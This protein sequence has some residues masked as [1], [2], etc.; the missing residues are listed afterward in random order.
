MVL[1]ASVVICTRN[2]PVLLSQ[3]V[4]SILAGDDVPAEIIVV[5]QSDNARRF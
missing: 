4:A 3:A 1:P 5:D 2:R